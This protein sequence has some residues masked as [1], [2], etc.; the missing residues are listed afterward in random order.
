MAGC[1][2]PCQFFSDIIVFMEIKSN[3]EPDNLVE[4]G[5]CDDCLSTF[6]PL[7]QQGVMVPLDAETIISPFLYQNLGLA[8]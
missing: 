4:L 7:L 8:P 5:L 6:S 3:Q 2:Q 1:L